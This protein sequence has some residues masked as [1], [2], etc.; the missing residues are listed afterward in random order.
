[1]ECLNTVLV[2]EP[3][4]ARTQRSEEHEYFDLT[5][6]HLLINVHSLCFW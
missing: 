6:F 3:L 5:N 4:S 2:L 1:M